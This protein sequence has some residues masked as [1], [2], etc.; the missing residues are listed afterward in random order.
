MRID[1]FDFNK[2][3]S[4]KKKCICFAKDGNT[5]VKP[6]RILYELKKIISDVNYNN[7]YIEKVENKFY[8]QYFLWEELKGICIRRVEIH[9]STEISKLLQNINEYKFFGVDGY[10]NML[11]ET[12]KEGGYINKLNIEVC[13]IL[14]EMDLAM[15]YKK[16]R[17]D[18]II[19]RE[20]YEKA[21]REARELIR[22]EKELQEKEENEKEIIKAE[23]NI[24]NHQVLINKPF[25]D[26]TIISY[27][28]KKYNV[29]VPLKTQGWINK[30]LAKIIYNETGISYTYY[31]GHKEST[32][33]YKCLKEL[34]SKI[35]ESA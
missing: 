20:S 5:V 15:N 28:M 31:K 23:N 17:E 33:F 11:N 14:G 4:V 27:L 8:N 2:I 16:Y 35:L 9:E 6:Y 19:T 24:R 22:I 26:N 18:F 10:L 13:M 3:E 7:F 34:E 21:E 32:V 29:K 1:E 25:L 30:A 12:E